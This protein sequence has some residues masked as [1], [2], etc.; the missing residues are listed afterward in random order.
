MAEI[1]KSDQSRNTSRNLGTAFPYG[2][3]DNINNLGN[4][5][6]PLTNNVNVMG[7]SPN[8]K[9]RRRNHGHRPY[10]RPFIHHVTLCQQASG[11]TSHSDKALL[12]SNDS[13]VYIV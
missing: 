9:T 8:N 13:F 10:N 1:P 2:C 11:S 4:M 12:C 5:T 7:L 3:N 6:S